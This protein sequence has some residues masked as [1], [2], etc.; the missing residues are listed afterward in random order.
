VVLHE[1]IKLPGKVSPVYLPEAEP[2]TEEPAAFEGGYKISKSGNAMMMDIK[3]SLNK[4]IYEREDWGAFRKAVSAQQKFANEP[5]I[6]KF[7]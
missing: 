6:L 7:N 4:R 3:V 2:F 1:N 5:V